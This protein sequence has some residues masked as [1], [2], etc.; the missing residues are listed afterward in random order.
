MPY[1]LRL[2]FLLVFIFFLSSLALTAQFHRTELNYLFDTNRFY[3]YGELGVPYQYDPDFGP[4]GFGAV[5]QRFSRS[6]IT[7]GSRNLS[8]NRFR[9]AAT[10]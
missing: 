6:A 5:H 1:K 10:Y 8:A 7:P 2:H 4:A 3:Y 9:L